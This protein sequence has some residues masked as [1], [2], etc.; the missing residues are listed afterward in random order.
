MT[1]AKLLRRSA[2]SNGIPM[3][4]ARALRVVL[5]TFAVSVCAAASTLAQTSRVA[6]DVVAAADV[7]HGSQVR[8]DSTV[9]LDAFGA[10]RIGD[11]FDVRVRPVVFR[12]SFDGSWQTQMYELA[13]RYE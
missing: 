4:T 9:W 3:G 7:D 1:E 10:V 2:R 8:R 13:L 6:L 11:N 5:F 12:R